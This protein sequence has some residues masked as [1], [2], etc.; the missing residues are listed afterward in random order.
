MKQDAHCMVILRDVCGSLG[1]CH[2]MI[3]CLSF[4][5]GL[6]VCNCSETMGGGGIMGVFLCFFWGGREERGKGKK[7]PMMLQVANQSTQNEWL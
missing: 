6:N 1:W 4:V 5:S 7:I 2:M 3:S